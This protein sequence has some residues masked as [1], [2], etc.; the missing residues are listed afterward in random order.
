MCRIAAEGIT[1][2]LVKSGQALRHPDEPFRQHGPKT[3]RPALL[4]AVVVPVRWL[5]E[6]SEACLREARY[7]NHCG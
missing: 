2:G 7:A 5:C 4:I 3:V 6:Q 1:L